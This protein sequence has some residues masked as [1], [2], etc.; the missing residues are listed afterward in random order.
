[1]SATPGRVVIKLGTSTLTG[2][3]AFLDRE[4][5]LETVRA[6]SALHRE[7][8]QV[9][10]VSSG[11]VAAGREALGGPKLPSDTCYKQ[12]LSSV[13]Q[14]RLF[15]IWEDLFSIYKLR[16]G[17]LLLTR[18]DLENRERYLNARETLQALFEYDVI[19]VINEN[20]A[21]SV[22]DIKIGDN[23]TL[24]ALIGVMIDAKKVILLTDQ[25]GLYSADPRADKNA[26]LI[27]SVPEVNAEILALAGGA[28]SAQGTGGMATK[29]RAASVA[30]SA[31]VG[32]VIASGN[33]PQQLPALARGEGVGTFFEP[34]RHPVLQRKSWLSS[35]TIS[36]GRIIV[37]AGAARAL[38]QKGSSLLPS[39]IV[40]VEG[41]FLR[42]AIVD[43]AGADGKEL[44]RG[45][46]RYGS[47]DLRLIRGRHSDEIENILGFT[48][49]AV[50]VHRDDLALRSAHERS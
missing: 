10:V 15:E 49:G 7:G 9:A 18:A 45:I 50:A 22:S 13:G 47:D 46:A 1:M 4:R 5:M 16:I 38:A 23:D 41:D 11:A 27:R 26:R 31:G 39:G 2:G 33:N 44:A 48:H 8:W 19:P 36:Q 25:D 12:M 29:V 37:D 3:T 24:A 20:D 14:G 28:G 6:V 35:A 43:I 30:T 32:F 40:R 21:L 17:Q 42:G 34:S